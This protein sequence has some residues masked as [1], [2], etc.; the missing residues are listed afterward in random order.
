VANR[1]EIEVVAK[2]LASGILDMIGT[3]LGGIKSAASVGVLVGAATA[4]T[5]FII[6][7]IEPAGEAETV[8]ARLAVALHASG[9]EAEISAPQLQTVAEKLA[10]MSTF[11]DEDIKT[12]FQ[13]LTQFSTVPTENFEAVAQMAMDMAAYGE[14]GGVVATNVEAIGRALETGII[15]RTWAFTDAQKEQFAALAESGRTADAL[16]YLLE[17]LNGKYGGQASAEVSTYAGQVKTLDKNWGEFKENIG[18]RYL[19]GLTDLLT[20]TND[21]FNGII[22]WS[23]AVLGLLNPFMGLSELIGQVIEAIG[24]ADFSGLPSW[25]YRQPG[26]EGP[27]GPHMATGGWGGGMTLVGETGPEMVS[28][29]QGS[30][31]HTAG[32]TA[33]MGGGQ[34]MIFNFPNYIGTRQDLEAAMQNAVRRMQNEGRA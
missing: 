17:V 32:E 20:W 15:P 7:T 22:N 14:G 23:N 26:D 6:S 1:V 28:L 9:R 27:P 24:T 19:P 33:R 8:N 2:D 31:V 4:Y 10:S 5:D 13:V 16:A 29:P 21:N 34:T 11:D 25:L 18:T 12:A 3:K 30:Y